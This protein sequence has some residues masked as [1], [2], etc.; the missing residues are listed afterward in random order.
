MGQVIELSYERP[1]MVGFHLH[2]MSIIGKSM[3]MEIDQWLPG[4][5]IWGNGDWLLMVIFWD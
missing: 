2:E 1:Q 3:E 4:L 5:G